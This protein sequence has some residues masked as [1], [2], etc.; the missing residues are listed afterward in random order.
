VWLGR[1]HDSGGRR[2]RRHGE[3]GAR[4]GVCVGGATVRG[5]GRGQQQ[6]ETAIYSTY[7]L[8]VV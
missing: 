6:E 1:Q 2:H 3:G 7:L 4:H 5:K 8:W